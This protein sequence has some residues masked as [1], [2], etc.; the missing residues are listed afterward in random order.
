[1]GKRL[2]D[3]AVVLSD[4][5]SAATTSSSWVGFGIQVYPFGYANGVFLVGT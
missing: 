5:A 3:W 4:Y 1:M 2:E